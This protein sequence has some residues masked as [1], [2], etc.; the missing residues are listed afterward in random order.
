MQGATALLCKA[1]SAGGVTAWPVTRLPTARQLACIRRGYPFVGAGRAIPLDRPVVASRVAGEG[2]WHDSEAYAVTAEL[3]G[4]RD[5]IGLRLDDGSPGPVRGLLVHCADRGGTR[6]ERACLGRMHPLLR[7][8]T[9]TRRCCGAGRTRP[10]SSRA[11]AAA[12]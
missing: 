1:A 3:L 4:T 2:P 5:V 7:A 8:W 10:P 9:G 12:A 11:R 6:R